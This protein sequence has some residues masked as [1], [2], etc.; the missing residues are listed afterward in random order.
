MGKGYA[1]GANLCEMEFLRT[2]GI[3]VSA[4]ANP[5]MKRVGKKADGSIFPGKT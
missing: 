3:S 1:L 2:E 5:S 4:A